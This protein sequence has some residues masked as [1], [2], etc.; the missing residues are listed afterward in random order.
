MGGRCL[1]AARSL[2]LAVV[3]A[4]MLA[5]CVAKVSG[6]AVKTPVTDTANVALMDTGNYPTTLGHMFGTAGDDKFAQSLLEAHR[7]ADFVVGPWQVNDTLTQRPPLPLV[8]QIGAIPDTEDMER[9]FGPEYS[10]IA[11]KPDASAEPS[12]Y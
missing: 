8:I 10:S 4:G 2:M 5:G 12:A 1:S 9:M 7:L 11:T 3:W 6:V